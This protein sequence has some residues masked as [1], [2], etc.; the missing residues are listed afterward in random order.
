VTVRLGVSQKL[1]RLV[2]PLMR[3]AAF[4]RAYQ[5]AVD[6]NPTPGVNVV[7]YFRAELGIAEVARQIV[8]S[9]ERAG[10]PFSTLTYERTL[11][12]QEHPFGSA[13][14]VTAPFD[15]NIICVNADQ[16]PYFRS[17]AGPEFFDQ[18]YSI[19]VWFWELARFPPQYHAAFDYVDEVWVASDFVRGAIAAATAKPVHVLP[20]PLGEAPPV[21]FSRD[22]LPLPEGFVFLFIFDFLSV[23]ERK[24]PLA[25]V[26]AFKLAFQPDEGAVLVIKSINGARATRSLRRLQAVAADRPDIH[27]IDGYVSA[28]TKDATIAAC[29]CYVSLHRSEGY[30]LT[31]AEAMAYGKPV[32]A[33]GYSGN[34]EFMN[35]GSSYLVP[36]RRVAIPRRCGPY[37]AGD[38]WAE[39][40]IAVAA[41]TMRR[42]YDHPDEAGE[43]GRRARA[44]LATNHTQ[45]RTAAF[46][47]AR[48]KEIRE[49]PLPLGGSETARFKDRR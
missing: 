37:P 46:I 12:R 40:D 7:G 31:M 29:D 32:I 2:S 28:D 23:F 18:R 8:R 39:P 27:I 25:V 43:I 16:L 17:E 14:A 15:T 38:E 10:I 11:S 47:S 36:F 26:E 34:L 4:G 22:E 20:L 41:Q 42:V 30:G 6:P 48:L 19:G 35:D 45:G 44:A 9:V 5:L 33:T 1:R 24:N 21:T 3:P 49:A 13:D